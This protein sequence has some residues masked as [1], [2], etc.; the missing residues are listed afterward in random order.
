MVGWLVVW[1]IM[2]SW[3][4]GWFF[5]VLVGWLVGW[6]VDGFVDHWLVLIGCIQLSTRRLFDGPKLS[7][8]QNLQPVLGLLLFLFC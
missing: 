7:H 3:L 1:S 5:E 4:V 2:I 6:L 8:I